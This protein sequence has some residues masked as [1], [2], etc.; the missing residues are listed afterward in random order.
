MYQRQPALRPQHRYVQPAS[1]YFLG[2]IGGVS[3][4][5]YKAT[6]EIED[7]T[8]DYDDFPRPQPSTSAPGKSNMPS[9]EDFHQQEQ[10]RIEEKRLK[11]LQAE[12]QRRALVDNFVAHAQVMFDNIS[13]PYLERLIA[14][15]RPKIAS[16]EELID[17]CIETIFKTNGKYPKAKRKRDH[18]DG[19]EDGDSSGSEEDFGLGG[20]N[21][22]QGS[23]TSQANP[24]AKRDFNDCSVKMNPQYLLDSAGQMFQ[25]FPTLSATSIRAVLNKF[26]Y[27]YVPAF[28]YITSLMTDDQTPGKGKKKSIDSGDI[29]LVEVKKP[30]KERP[31]VSLNKLDPDFRR[32]LL[33]MRSKIE[34]EQAEIKDALAEEEN[35]RVHTEHNNLKEW[36]VVFVV[37]V[38]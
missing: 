21:S 20:S 14:D 36:Y 28:E 23:S 3:R 19:D 29:R 37:E 35:L 27:H 6:I 18:E 30:R 12:E 25:D 38:L 34:K 10:N 15:N 7:D 16:D 11:D 4:H 31:P 5:L 9:F 32:E 26:S 22:Y 33:W 24:R 17:T 2:P 8:L 1:K 13:T